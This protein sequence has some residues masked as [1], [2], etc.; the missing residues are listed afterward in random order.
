MK[1][2]VCRRNPKCIG[3]ETDTRARLQIFTFEEMLLDVK[4]KQ[5]ISF[6]LIK[7]MSRDF[8][9][10][11]QSANSQNIPACMPLMIN[12]FK[13]TLLA[14]VSIPNNRRQGTNR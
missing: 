6:S 11:N 10:T 14:A 13:V 8:I 12:E 9:R 2:G 5:E 3:I 4:T 1:P 7:V